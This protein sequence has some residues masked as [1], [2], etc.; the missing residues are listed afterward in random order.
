MIQRIAAEPTLYDA[1]AAG[2][3]PLH[4]RRCTACG[5]VFFPPQDYGCEGCGAEPERI[6]ALDLPGA[7][8]VVA[9]VELPGSP[10]VAAGSP[11]ARQRLA[12]IV[13]DCG[14]AVH[15]V[16]D[17][18]PGGVS[19]GA[20]VRSALVAVGERDGRELVELHFVI[21]EGE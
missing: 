3:P 9:S 19:P 1:N 11:P 4:G 8:R 15:A 7:G 5:R 21:A 10:A 20:R 14:P 17:A 13:L 12:T 16:L 6:A 2:V 18:P